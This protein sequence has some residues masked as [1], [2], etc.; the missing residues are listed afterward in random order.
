MI[1][2]D[3]GGMLGDTDEWSSGIHQQA[4]V[5]LDEA[6]L[7][8]FMVDVLKPLDHKEKKLALDIRR[9]K[10]PVILISNKVNGRYFNFL[11]C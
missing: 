2:V 11:T 10:K 8:L 3:T 1:L 4:E 5:A 6:D 7:I 9:R